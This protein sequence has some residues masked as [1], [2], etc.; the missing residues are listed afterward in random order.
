MSSSKKFEEIIK[1]LTKVFTDFKGDKNKLNGIA[2][3]SFLDQFRITNK[4]F[5]ANNTTYNWGMGV[6][7]GRIT[8][9]PYLYILDE[10]HTTSP[11]SGYYIAII[12]DEN[13][14]TFYLT[15]NQGISYQDYSENE[16]RKIRQFWTNQG[17][18]KS[19]FDK[20]SDNKIESIQFATIPNPLLIKYKNACIL[21]KKFHREDFIAYQ[22]DFIEE[23]EN[24]ISLYGNIVKIIAK[25]NEHQAVDDFNNK[26]IKNQ[27]LDQ[28]DS[29]KKND[30]S[31]KSN[32]NHN[33]TN[34]LT[35]FLQKIKD[36][37]SISKGIVLFFGA[38]LSQSIDLPG[39]GDLIYKL[40]QRSDENLGLLS[41]DDEN[42]EDS[43]KSKKFIKNYAD[44]YVLG[45][46]VKNYYSKN[47]DTNIKSYTKELHDILYDKKINSETRNEF[48]KKFKH[49]IY[50]TIYKATTLYKTPIQAIVTYNYDNCLEQT[51]ENN[52]NKDFYSI[53]FNEQQIREMDNSKKLPIYHVHGY[54]PF[55]QEENDQN[56]SNSLEKLIEYGKSI[57]LT[58][59]EYH[60]LFS[61]FFNWTNIVQ[62]KYLLEYT[63]VFMGFSLTDLN[64]RRLLESIAK[65]IPDDQQHFVFLSSKKEKE[66]S[67]SEEIRIKLNEAQKNLNKKN[68][69]LETYIID[70]NDYDEI[71]K[72]LKQSIEEISKY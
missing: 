51:F 4:H 9:C 18:L 34:D 3:S 14:E 50:N 12:F 26:V 52:D 41:I 15:L 71:N 53:I 30:I 40:L 32:D 60:R 8:K 19:F 56:D 59:T 47:D 55:M 43:K 36:S 57:V 1:H 62:M 48:E 22:D 66:G 64:Q 25:Y 35:L 61:D 11:T 49:S 39:W 2:K 45:S 28:P 38:G 7:H 33:Y 23:L 31:E 65:F 27:F 16:Y 10:K 6:G 42:D 13:I 72:I 29:K 17:E 70:Y 21:Y 69:S 67:K 37:Q 44:T 20:Y 58:E 24:F 5:D 46:L 68:L 63:C 54:L